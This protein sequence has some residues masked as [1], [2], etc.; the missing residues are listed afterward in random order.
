MKTF[1]EKYYKYLVFIVAMFIPFIYAFFYLKAYWD[2]YGNLSD[3][4][5]AI[6]N[7]DKEK[8]HSTEFI[9]SLKE[10]DTCN[11]KVVN[12]NIADTG[13]VD[14]KYYAVITIPKDFSSNLDNAKTKKRS[15]T[16]LT[17]SANQK[18]NFLASQILNS[19]VNEAESSLNYD[20]DSKLVKG[21]SSSIEDMPNSLEK[22][23]DASSTL[24]V[25]SSSLNDGVSS[26]K[27]GTTSLT[28]G[29]KELNEN[30]KTASDGSKKLASGTN[31]LNEGL[32]KIKEGSNSLKN[33]SK[34]VNEGIKRV[35]TSTN[36]LLQNYEAFNKGISDFN[37][38]FSQL[39]N[40]LNDLKNGSASLKQGVNSYTDNTKNLVTLINTCEIAKDETGQMKLDTDYNNMLKTNYGIDCNNIKVLSEGLTND[41]T[42]NSLKNGAL[43]IDEGIETSKNG[44]SSLYEGS[45]KLKDNSSAILEGIK[46]LKTG[47]S[48]LLSGSNSLVKGT[49]DLDN[50]LLETKKGTKT[51][52]DNTNALSNGL[53][54]LASGSNQLLEGT[55]K[56]NSGVT[57][58]KEGTKQ[59][60]DGIGEFKEKVTD[61][62]NE[63]KEKVKDLKGINTYAKKPLIIKKKPY[64]K[65]N[66][67]GES[68]VPLFLSIGLWVGALLSY[69]VFYYDR[70]KKFKHL[71]VKN[72]SLKQDLMYYGVSLIY[73]FL[74]A[75]LI[76]LFL[77]LNVT[78]LGLY[79]LGS[80][81]IS[82]TFMSIVQFFIR[83]FGDLGKF[84][85]LIVLILQLT[86]SGGT[87]PIE[88]VTKGFRIFNPFLPM[89]YS[90][91]L[92]KESIFKL[93]NNF[94]LRNILILILFIAISFVLNRIV[95][96]IKDKKC[97]HI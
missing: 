75:F 48:S 29:T 34:T 62:T 23:V 83:S 43:A 88:T 65:I 80:M 69:L 25:G 91:K 55:N 59:L 63:T 79:Y 66:T 76:K 64:A 30:L 72:A 74:T 52:S 20:I 54:K 1:L 8:T 17:Y 22:I 12:E 32:N 18:S 46:S 14:G 86:A 33:G 44:A 60:D 78:N 3:L 90:I 26:L 24:K 37:N 38:N 85:A 61:S 4:N 70:A 19:V 11:F 21:L 68:F 50:A 51:I 77:G 39:V 87:F 28:N 2:P 93:D 13:L 73:G 9:D 5:V 47:L 56:L 7:L 58:L 81:L 97:S 45:N 15:K 67:Y 49:N 94:A 95:C 41:Q 53:D 6:V 31:D 40:G 89:T 84:L 36:S 10:S 92:I 42:V 82:L 16:T 35:D 96:F 71:D 57:S 27:D